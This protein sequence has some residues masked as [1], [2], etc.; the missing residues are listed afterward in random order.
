MQNGHW[1]EASTRKISALLKNLILGGGF[2]S[3]FH[4]EIARDHGIRSTV[5]SSAWR[6]HTRATN[7]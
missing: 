4:R 3:V 6:W 5:F 1:I 7:G 2:G